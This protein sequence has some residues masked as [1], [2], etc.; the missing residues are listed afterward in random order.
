M[1]DGFGRKV[2][3]IGEPIELPGPGGIQPDLDRRAAQGGQQG[4]LKIALKIQ[5]HIK[6]AIGEFHGHFDKTGHSRFSLE[7]KDL[8]HRRMALNQGGTGILQKPG[9]L[10]L[11]S[12]P[13]DGIDDRKGVN[14]IPHGTQEDDA[15][16]G[17]SG[18]IH[19]DGKSSRHS[20]FTEDSSMPRSPRRALLKRERK[21]RLRLA[22]STDAFLGDSTRMASTSRSHACHG[23]LALRDKR[24]FRA[25]K[26]G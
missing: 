11:G 22:V 23:P 18:E 15:D 20:N 7:K 13:L 17:L 3:V 6:G 14:H 12:V 2:A 1:A 9:D 8:V 16:A 21:S 19:R 25:F 5:H 26:S 10:G 4:G 24:M